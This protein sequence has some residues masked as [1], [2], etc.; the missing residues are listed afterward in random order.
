MEPPTYTPA[1]GDYVETIKDKRARPGSVRV[2][3][4]ASRAA[5]IA[6]TC[7]TCGTLTPVAGL[8]RDAAKPGG[9]QLRCRS[10]NAAACAAYSAANRE[11]LRAYHR[12]RVASGANAAAIRRWREA[13]PGAA[14]ADQRARAGRY[15]TRTEEQVLA[16]RARLRPD[17]VKRCR[18]CR[19]ALPLDAFSVAS[20]RPDGLQ[21]NCRTC[22]DP[23]GHLAMATVHTDDHDGY[24]CYLCDGP[25]EHVDHVWPLA[26]GGQDVPE[27]CRWACAECNLSKNAT[28]LFTWR[29]D[30]LALVRDWPCVVRPLPG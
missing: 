13:N 18:K 25:A 1:P 24:R 10:C 7:T 23:W 16:D 2:W 20:A 3:A 14:A 29:P 19:E 15:S 30:L 5:L 17:G 6:A 26:L 28:P 27:N 12:A 8:G 22:A 21:Q 11:A 4:D 9:Y